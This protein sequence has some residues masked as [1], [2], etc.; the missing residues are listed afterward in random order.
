MS[1]FPE[2]TPL[3]MPIHDLLDGFAVKVVDDMV[4]NVR[5]ETRKDF[6]MAVK[7]KPWST[8]LFKLYA[9]DAGSLISIWERLTPRSDLISRAKG[10]LRA[11]SLA[12]LERLL[13]SA[14][15]QVVPE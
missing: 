11:Q 5:A 9:E 1:H 13:E 8:A 10:T 12:S 3:I 7:A 2:M 14:G 4:A 15:V 6:A